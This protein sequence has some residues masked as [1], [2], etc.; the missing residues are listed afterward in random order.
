MRR[1]AVGGSAVAMLAAAAALVSVTMP[2][3]HA[4]DTPLRTLAEAKG[5]YMGTALMQN[6][7]TGISASIAGT[8]FDSV[9]PGNEMKWESVEPTRGTY[10]W[11]PADQ[12]VSFAQANNMQVRG[13]NLVW[14]S[15]L[16]SWL[17]SGSFTN[18]QLHDIMI[19]HVTDEVTHFKGKVVHWDVVN[20]PFNEDGTFRSDLWYNQLG[21]SYIA[22]ALTAARAADP[23][24]KLYINDY[25][26]EGENAK[27]NGLYNL[28]KS[29]KQQG[30]PIDGVG[31][32]AHFILGQVPSDFKANLQRFA[33]LGVDVAVTELDVRMQTPADSTKL[34]QQAN[35]Y[36]A[37][38]NDCLGVTRCVGV[39]VWG[40]NDATSWVPSTFPGQGA[41]TPY[42]ENYQPK[43]AYYAIQAALGGNGTPPTTP[44]TSPPT[45]QPSTPPPGGNCAVTYG[46]NQWNTGFTANI[47]VKNTG[48]A[49]I[50]GWTLTW[51]QA[52][53]T[54]TVTQAWN[55]TVTKSGTAYTAKNLSYNGAIA[56]GA[57]TSFGFNADWSGSN[58]T[59]TGFALNGGACTVS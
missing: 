3:A 8:Q 51:N 7:L 23:N 18:Q 20:E 21:S 29:L 11:G 48:S 52:S 56:V 55:A 54:Q 22:D 14:H 1:S 40:F 6:E 27:S 30:V 50:S 12:I 53:G 5:I 37:V 46:V 44:P 28:V 35:D 36:T 24:A 41:A 16:P 2:S 42:D 33:D 17:T 58:P 10:N 43:P 26:V 59:P 9:T 32:Q 38:M 39:T 49:P 25:N 57:S 4:A 45:T 31:F 34:Q 19:K 15:Q 47:T 13:H